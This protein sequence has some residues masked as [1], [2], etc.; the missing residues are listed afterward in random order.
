[1]LAP[2]REAAGPDAFAA[3][4]ACRQALDLWRGAALVEFQA[5]FAEAEAARLEELRL[6]A[7]E[8]R[9]AADIALGR[10]A[11]LTGELEALGRLCRGSRGREVVDVL[12][13]LAP[14]RL[15]QLPGAASQAERER[16][17][18]R[19]QGSNRERMLREGVE[20]FQALARAEPLVLLVEDLH[21]SDASTTD[22]LSALARRADKA[23]LLVIATY[24]P[25]PVESELGAIHRV[26]RDLRLRDH[27]SELVLPTLTEEAVGEYL[28][29]RLDGGAPPDGLVRV[30]TSRRRSRATPARRSRWT[31]AE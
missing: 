2:A 3:A 27:A 23:L 19:A 13:E 5:P 25:V 24:R 29:T 16:A 15:V 10:H 28:S 22:L 7:L 8:E 4:E 26:A 6:A 18:V 11:Q 20:A 31:G 1:M 12:A 17:E 21:W 30:P 14:T 9:I